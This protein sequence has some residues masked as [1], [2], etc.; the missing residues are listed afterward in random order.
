MHRHDHACAKLPVDAV[1]CDLAKEGRHDR[2]GQFFGQDKHE[3]QH[4]NP[5]QFYLPFAL[6]MCADL[7]GGGVDQGIDAFHELADFVMGALAVQQG[8]F[9]VA[10]IAQNLARNPYWQGDIDG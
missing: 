6:G 1:G 7:F 3:G 9:A 10:H 4:A 5:D 8:E 2:T